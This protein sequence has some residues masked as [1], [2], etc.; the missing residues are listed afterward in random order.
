[1]NMKSGSSA[2]KQCV[3]RTPDREP[4]VVVQQMMQHSLPVRVRVRVTKKKKKK[5]KVVRVQQIGDEPF[6][7][8]RNLMAKMMHSHITHD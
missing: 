3:Q 8:E 1:M 6:V 7:K 5:R 4:L 2:M